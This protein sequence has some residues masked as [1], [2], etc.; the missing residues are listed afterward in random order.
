M[1]HILHTIFMEDVIN[2]IDNKYKELITYSKEKFYT[3]ANIFMM[4]LYYKLFTYKNKPNY[5]LYDKLL[6]K[7]NYEVINLSIRHI[8][9]HSYNQNLTLLLYSYICNF[10]FEYYFNNYISAFSNYNKKTSPKS[11]MFKYSKTS[12]IIESQLY[13]ER[14]YS[15][16]NKYR[17]DTKQ[18]IVADECF[19]LLDE[20]F[21]QQYLMSYGIDVFIESY[22]NFL[23]YQNKIYNN[24]NK[25]SKPVALFLDLITK[26]KKYSASSIYQVKNKKY[27]DY[28]NKEN[29][30]WIRDQHETT[31]SFYELYNEAKQFTVKLLTLVSEN[32]Y[33]QIKNNELILKEIS[34][35]KKE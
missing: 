25:L 8:Q 2:N 4:P 15:N 10:V 13:E 27:E 17:L 7:N 20:I 26:S 1:N 21:S 35:I 34:K 33:Y 22:H 3:Y 19:E 9:E 18:I 6:T 11:Q 32:I 5:N 31:L 14:F 23:F 16:V 24:K 28:L 30:V 12:K 29:H